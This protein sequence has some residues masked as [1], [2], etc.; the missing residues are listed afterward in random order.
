MKKYLALVLGMVFV[1]GFAASAFAIHAEIPSDTQAVVAK[2]KTQIELGGIIRVRGFFETDKDFDKNT[3]DNTSL[4]ETMIRL[5]VHAKVTPNTEAKISIRDT[6]SNGDD[7]YT[8]GSTGGDT[9]GLYVRGGN[10]GGYT[11]MD[12]LTFVEAWIQHKGSGLLGIPA[13]IKI[14]HMPI[15]FG[16]GLFFDHTKNGEDGYIL[17]MDPTKDLH[18]ALTYAKLYEGTTTVNDDANLYNLLFNYKA[19]KDSGISADVTYIDDQRNGINNLG[20]AATTYPYGGMGLWNI[21]LR[22]NTKV[23]G[24]GINADVEM[25]TGKSKGIGTTTTNDVKYKGYAYVVGIDYKIAPVK[26]G[27]EYAYGSGDSA[28]QDNKYKGFITLLDNK[29]KFSWIYEYRVV[30]PTGYGVTDSQAGL[31]NTRYVKASVGVDLAKDLDAKLDFYWLRANKVAG[32]TYTDSKDIGTE[33]DWLLS[34]KIDKNLKYFV[35]GGYLFAGDFYKNVATGGKNPDNPYA[36]RHG[37][38][39]SF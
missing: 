24:F 18:L 36:V 17:F 7:D 34:Y 5:D 27:L 30:A 21:G 38:V 14:G 33:I 23:G 9:K 1:L 26:L 22:G 4:Y 3:P 31:N 11:D 6:K 16:K 32:F 20:N 29:Q 15:K 13:G 35:E 19:G 2:G 12:K 10:A 39:L 25:Q 28:N 8:W 37:I